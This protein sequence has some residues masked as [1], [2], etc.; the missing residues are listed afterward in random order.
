MSKINSTISAKAAEAA[1]MAVI[2]DLYV[3]TDEK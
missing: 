3:K 2:S 1:E